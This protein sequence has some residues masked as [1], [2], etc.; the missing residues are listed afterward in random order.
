[1]FLPSYFLPV[2]L[3]VTVKV[4]L[5][6]FPAASAAVTVRRLGPFFRSIEETL[7]DDVPN[8][9]APRPPRSFVHV[10]LTTPTLSETVPASETVAVLVA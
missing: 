7:H 10:T 5:A 2:T 4:V 8:A 3:L 9:A 6:A 1:M